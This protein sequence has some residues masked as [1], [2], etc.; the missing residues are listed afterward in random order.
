MQAATATWQPVAGNLMTRWAQDVDP[1][2]PLPE[3]P[4]PQLVRSHW[5]SLNGLWRYAITEKDAT[6]PVSYAGQILVPYPLESALSG[7]KK[8]L[9]PNQNLWYQ[10]TFARPELKPGERLLLHFDAVDFEATVF[11]NGREVGRH[12]GGYQRFSVDITEAL[13][14]GS[15]ELQVKVWDP[16][17][18]GPNPHG[19]QTLQPR[20]IYYT[21][22]SGIWQTVWL[23]AVP[24]VSIRSLVLTPDVNHGVLKLR[25]ESNASEGF[26]VRASSGKSRIAGQPN[27][28]LSLAIASPRLWSPDDPY[29]YDLEVR[30]LKN[31]ATVDRVRSYFGMRKVE[32][33]K[34]EQGQARIYLNNRYLYN[35]GVL[36]QGFWPDGLYTAPSDAALRFDVETIKSWGFNTIRKHIKIEPDRWYYHCDKLGLLV[37]QDMVPP[38]LESQELPPTK[39]ARMQFEQE[40]AESLAQLHNHPSITT[41]VLFNE[42]W[43]DYDPERLE[44][45]IKQLDPSR[46]LNGHSGASILLQGKLVYSVGSAGAASDL[47]DIHSYPEPAIPYTKDKA[48]VLGEYGGIGVAIA[49]HI[50]KNDGAGWGYVQVTPAKLADTYTEF[51]DQIKNLEAQ[52]ELG[53]SLSGSIYTQPFDV[54]NEL[55]GLM[56]YDRAVVKIPKDGLAQ[57]HR[58]LTEAR[59]AIPKPPPSSAPQFPSAFS[60][61]LPPGPR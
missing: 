34:D 14:R 45:W 50:W 60:P 22:T 42:G 19:K 9:L 43:G 21:A 41:W 54:E 16:T 10:K 40:V 29:L 17:D 18:K 39:E 12:R 46:L 11:M 25:V 37:W 28:T 53:A 56:T 57:L 33:K 15:N 13:R 3:Y 2:R 61:P 32:V 4:R 58:G 59:T 23:E 55:N 1:A 27:E 38:A 44:H 48:P 52:N 7:V 49:G 5:Q 26:T 8:S 20:G 30:L 6:A 31:G 35:L 47:A 24:A 36:D 51:M